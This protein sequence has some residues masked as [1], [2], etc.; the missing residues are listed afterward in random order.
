MSGRFDGEVDLRFVQRG[1]RTVANRRYHRGNSR[2]SSD[3]PTIDGIPYYF[4]ISTGGGFTEG[5]HYQQ[6]VVLDA[7]THAILTTQAPNYIYKC[8]HQRLTTL[9]STYSVGD[10]AL[11]ECYLDETIPYAN[12]YYEQDTRIELGAHA[13]LILTDG[14]TGGWSPD[15][16]PF[17]Y[18]RI[19][20]K[21]TIKQDGHLVFNDRM[22]CDPQ[23]DSMATMGFFEGYSNYNSVVFIDEQIT[24]DTVKQ[25]RDV[26]DEATTT[27][28]YGVSLLATNGMV[29]RMLGPDA[30]ENHALLWQAINYYREQVAGLAPITLRKHSVLA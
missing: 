29:L 17:M 3:I 19:G 30:H 28:R 12:A 23:I 8:D 24:A 22:L 11:L 20:L 13:R 18:R 27:T 2:L 16:N 4:L 15:D 21:T 25:L 9:E 6:N 26:L 10:S 14:L 1:E 7:N 5:E